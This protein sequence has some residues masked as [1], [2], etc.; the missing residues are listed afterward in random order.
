MFC[1]SKILHDIGYVLIAFSILWSIFVGFV[2]YKNLKEINRVKQKI[3]SK[4]EYMQ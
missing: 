4:N 1:V 3:K 2:A